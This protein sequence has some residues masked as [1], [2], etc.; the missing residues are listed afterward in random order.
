MTDLI[1]ILQLCI[2]LPTLYLLSNDIIHTI[3]LM[4]VKS[5]DIG[6][7]SAIVSIT[8]VLCTVKIFDA[9]LKTLL[10]LSLN[11]DRETFLIKV[12]DVN[13][14]ETEE[15]KETEKTKGA[16]GAKGAKEAK[17]TKE[18]KEAKE[19]N[20]AKE[21]KEANEAKETK[22]TQDKTKDEFSPAKS[23]KHR[24]LSTWGFPS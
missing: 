16:K 15:A 6:L 23:H 11:P 17:E 20:E 13:I 10:L 5:D 4:N 1:E 9:W 24:K 19:A 2:A 3:M 14:E 18:A 7:K 21:T 8:L 12:E 22:E